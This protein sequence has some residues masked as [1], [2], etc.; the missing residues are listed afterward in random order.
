MITLLCKESVYYLLA[1]NVKD[2]C[3][4]ALLFSWVITIPMIRI[5][6]FIKNHFPLKTEVIIIFLSTAF[7]DPT[8]QL[9]VEMS[10]ESYRQYFLIPVDIF[11]AFRFSLFK[12]AFFFFIIIT[13]TNSP[14]FPVPSNFISFFISAIHFFVKEYVYYLRQ[15]Y[16]LWHGKWIALFCIN[17]LILKWA[18]MKPVNSV[19]ISDILLYSCFTMTL[20]YY[21]VSVLIKLPYFTT[22]SFLFCLFFYFLC[23]LVFFS[24]LAYSVSFKVQ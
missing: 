4:N 10:L 23:L 13:I 14:F 8:W 1:L 17:Y 12:I 3:Q 7:S 9:D 16:S 6:G 11:W 24:F 2:C 19:T 20:F 15:Q 22:S 5:L 18:G 21:R